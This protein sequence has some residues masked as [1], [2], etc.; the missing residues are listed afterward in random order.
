MRCLVI[1]DDKFE[2]DGLRYMIE[3]L[4]LDWEIR[5]VRN[6]R[7]GLELMEREL[8]D[9]V[10]TDIKMPVMDGIAFLERARERWPEAV[11]I[12]YSGHSDFEYAKKAISL[13]VLE[14]L[15]KPVSDTEFERIMGRAIRRVETRKQN[16][17]RRMLEHLRDDQSLTDYSGEGGWLYLLWGGDRLK[18]CRSRL[19]EE[20]SLLAIGGQR[21]LGYREGVR[22]TAETAWQDYGIEGGIAAGIGSTWDSAAEAYARM[23]E[24]REGCIFRRGSVVEE[25]ACRLHLRPISLRKG[26]SGAGEKREGIFE[27]ISWEQALREALGGR[28]VIRKDDLEEILGKVAGGRSVFLSRLRGAE[29]V[30]ELEQ[31]LWEGDPEESDAVI[32]EVRR[33]INEHYPEELSV[34]T[35]AGA[36]YLTPSYLCTIFKKKTGTTLGHYITQYRMERAMEL[37]KAGKLKTAEVARR[38]GYHNISYFNLVFKARTGMTPGSYR[39][40]QEHQNAE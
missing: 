16:V 32:Y 21:Y 30:E 1:D 27:E 25:S 26:D 23:K 37:L 9:I 33:Y 19:E 38:V 5:D 2:R 34:E 18:A 28:N 3:G 22:K 17:V 12:I 15:V 13:E 6:G 31:M 11:Y 35:L 14:F 4:G 39:R 8:F 40:E 36:V 29:T 20:I 7:L 10:I 24:A